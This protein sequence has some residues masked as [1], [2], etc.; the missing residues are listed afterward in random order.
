MKFWKR[1]RPDSLHVPNITDVFFLQKPRVSHSASVYIMRLFCN[2]C[3]F[4]NWTQSIQTIWTFFVENSENITNYRTIQYTHTQL[5]C[6]LPVCVR[7]RWS[8]ESSHVYVKSVRGENTHKIHDK[9][10]I[11]FSFPVLCGLKN[12]EWVFR[13]DTMV[14]QK[15]T[16]V[17][18]TPTQRPHQ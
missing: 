10:L 5:H 9:T 7:Q 6:W 8:I 13:T 4:P 17:P 2:V 15:D 18:E 11:S 12:A 1:G 14:V 16:A 3:S